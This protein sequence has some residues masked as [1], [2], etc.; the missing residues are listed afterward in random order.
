M[1]LNIIP[2]ILFSS[3]PITVPLVPFNGFIN[4]I[5]IP[6]PPN[7]ILIGH[8]NQHLIVPYPLMNRFEMIDMNRP[9]ILNSDN[10]NDLINELNYRQYGHISNRLVSLRNVFWRNKYL[11]YKTKY[12]GLKG[13][14]PWS[15]NKDTKV[16]NIIIKYF[17]DRLNDIPPDSGNINKEIM[18]SLYSIITGSNEKKYDKYEIQSYFNFNKININVDNLMGELNKINDEKKNQQQKLQQDKIRAIAREG[19]KKKICMNN[20]I[21]CT[22]HGNI[23]CDYHGCSKIWVESLD[24]EISINK[25]NKKKPDTYPYPQ[26]MEDIKEYNNFYNKSMDNFK[27]KNYNIEG[28]TQIKALENKRKEYIYKKLQA[29]AKPDSLDD[30]QLEPSRIYSQEYSISK[31]DNRESY[32][33]S[34]IRSVFRNEPS[35]KALGKIP[36]KKA[37]KIN[38]KG[39]GIIH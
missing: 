2:N 31:S 24:N 16:K 35:T 37:P 11:K 36:K 19:E 1:N 21:A 30:I 15:S 10:I 23:N 28:L 5:N 29:V 33:D 9:V 20:I 4:N 7:R 12:L 17:T 22:E 38:H 34:K 32:E 3:R 6:M 14:W 27:Y 8:P 39:Y 25:E 18:D 13:G 26:F